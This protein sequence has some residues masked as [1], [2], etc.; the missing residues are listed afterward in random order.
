MRRSS[1]SPC[2]GSRGR[3][4]SGRAIRIWR[5]PAVPHRLA[6]SPC[7]SRMQEPCCIRR[8]SPSSN[9]RD[10]QSGRRGR[11]EEGVADPRGGSGR[12]GADADRDADPDGR[13]VPDQEVAARSA[14]LLS[15]RLATHPHDAA[16]PDSA[17]TALNVPVRVYYPTPQIVAHVPA[18]ARRKNC[19]P[20]TCR[21]SSLSPLMVGPRRAHR[22]A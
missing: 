10:A 2:A 1:S 18:V 16:S 8:G 9:P 15:A 5:K 7:A 20:T 13:L 6:S 14:D 3:T 4:C 22:G 17:A 12:V 11:A 19:I 21:S